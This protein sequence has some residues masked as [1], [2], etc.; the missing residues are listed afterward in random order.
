MDILNDIFYT[1]IFPRNTKWDFSIYSVFLLNYYIKILKKFIIKFIIIYNFIQGLIQEYQEI[2]KL[3]IN[4]YINIKFK[5][6]IRKINNCQSTLRSNIKLN[7]L[8]YLL[9]RILFLRKSCRTFRL[10]TL[11]MGNCIVYLRDK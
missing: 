11:I 10:L 4:H 6:K 3:S 1:S 2:F 9:F 5:F 8:D 7:L